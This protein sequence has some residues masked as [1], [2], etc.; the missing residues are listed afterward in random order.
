MAD[1]NHFQKQF[2]KKLLYIVKRCFISRERK[3]NFSSLWVFFSKAMRRTVKDKTKRKTRENFNFQ[4]SW[5][6][7]LTFLQKDFFLFSFCCFYFSPFLERISMYVPN[8]RNDQKGG[9][10]KMC[11]EE[12]ESFSKRKIT[13]SCQCKRMGK[14]L[15]FSIKRNTILSKNFNFTMCF[16]HI[17]AT[18]LKFP[19]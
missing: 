17:T 2:Q 11:P 3:K 18:N 9:G 13:I 14:V 1:H 12:A 7:T 4:H 19:Y 10:K 5:C 16:I 15:P 6:G 8:S